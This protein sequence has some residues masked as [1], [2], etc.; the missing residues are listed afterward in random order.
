MLC[1]TVKIRP[2]KIREVCGA[3]MLPLQSELAGS[4]PAGEPVCHFLQR[5]SIIR[6]SGDTGFVSFAVTL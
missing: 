3:A 6:V 2:K 1:I 5:F 4:L